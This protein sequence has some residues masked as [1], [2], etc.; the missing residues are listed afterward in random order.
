MV[1]KTEATE[2][3]PAATES[4]TVEPKAEKAT[5]GPRKI[6]GNLPYLT[7]TGTLKKVLDKVI[8]LAKPDKF[9]YDFL[10]NVVKLTGGAARACIPIMKKMG[11]LNSDNTTTDLYG[12]FR[13]EGGRSSAA[14]TALRNAF[15]EIFKRSDYAYKVE[16][17][18]LRDIIVEITGLKA[19]DPVTMAIKG[20]FNVLKAYVDP[21]FNPEMGDEEPQSAP[22]TKQSPELINVSRGPTQRPLGLSY[23]I[24]IVLPETS[25]LAVLNAIFKSVR[26]NLLS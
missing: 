19:S 26:E 10:E 25:D 5:P 22:E 15:P 4:G 2:P 14:Y 8:E 6:P 16:D 17:A 7:A 23:N 18:K 20:T 12:R 24:N 11:M 1:S 13:T 21:S 3:K 9:N